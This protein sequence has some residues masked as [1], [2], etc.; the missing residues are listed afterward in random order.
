MDETRG[1]RIFC[2]IHYLC[3]WLGDKIT[4]IPPYMALI[5]NCFDKKSLIIE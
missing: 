4:P 2:I 1:N 3:D 5:K